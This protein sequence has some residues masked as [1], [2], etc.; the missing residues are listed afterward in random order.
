MSFVQPVLEF[1]NAARCH[2]RVEQ[3][4]SSWNTELEQWQSSRSIGDNRHTAGVIRFGS[5]VTKSERGVGRKGYVERGKKKNCSGL[6]DITVIPKR[7]LS[8][9]HYSSALPSIIRDMASSSRKK[10]KGKGYND[11]DNGREQPAGG[12]R[13]CECF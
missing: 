10:S 9:S 1:W 5:A 4:R 6:S 8:Y 11:S 13:N 3:W 2:R 7:T 12:A